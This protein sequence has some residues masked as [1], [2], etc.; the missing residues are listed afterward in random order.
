MSDDGIGNARVNND[1]FSGNACVRRETAAGNWQWA[2]QGNQEFK[3]Q[4]SPGHVKEESVKLTEAKD[5]AACETNLELIQAATTR[6]TLIFLPYIANWQDRTQA[7][8]LAMSPG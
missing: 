8:S 4:L 6:L 1:I 2:R 5:S 7:A 3:E